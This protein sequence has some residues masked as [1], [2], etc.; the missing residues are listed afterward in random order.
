MGK[1]PLLRIDTQAR[2]AW[3]GGRPV[4]V[5]ATAF[6]ILAFLAAPPGTARSRREIYRVA[7]GTDWVA[8]AGKTLGQHVH[9]IRKEL[10]DKDGLIV[11]TVRGVGYRLDPASLEDRPEPPVA[12]TTVE[13]LHDTVTGLQ[14]H[15]EARAQE[16]A[17]PLIEEARRTADERVAAAEREL[18]AERQRREDLAAEFRRQIAALERKLPRRLASTEGARVG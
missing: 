3:Y 15:I 14:G 1:R 6:N 9:L 2:Q 12:R 11:R 10:G 8:G 4:K 7:W 13:L 16:I 5:S 18:A 17:A